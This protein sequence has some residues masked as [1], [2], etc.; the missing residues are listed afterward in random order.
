[1]FYFIFLM[2]KIDNINSEVL[3]HVSNTA[4]EQ[5]PIRARRTFTG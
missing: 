3:Y 1:M 2:L 5:P 4:E